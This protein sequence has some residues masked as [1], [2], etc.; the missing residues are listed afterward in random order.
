GTTRRALRGGGRGA[1]PRRRRASE[2]GRL[3]RARRDPRRR[4]GGARD[5]RGEVAPPP[6]A[7]YRAP[8]M[9]RTLGSILLA[10]V[11]FVVAGEVLARALHVV[12]RLNGYSRLLYAPGPS[13]D[14]PYVLRPNVET[15][16]VGIPVRTNALGF[17][18]PAVAAAPAPGVRRV[19]IG[20]DSVG[21]RPSV[22]EDVT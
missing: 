8:R 15:T 19:A 4:A 6:G 21:F 11:V 13:L 14:L 20:G 10:A 18:G 17:R 12:D 9:R 1:A 16:L 2:R 3:R 7:R 22:G 5:R